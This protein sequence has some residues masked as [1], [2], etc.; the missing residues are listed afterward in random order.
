MKIGIVCPYSFDAPGGVQY[1]VRDLATE[2]IKRGHDVDVLAPVEKA[3]VPDFITAVSGS[4]SIP[5]NG[6]VAQLSLSPKAILETR[7]WLEHGNFD[8][9]HIHEP[10]APSI[11]LIALA[12]AKSPIVATFHTSMVKSR[13]LGLA[14]PI[15]RPLL[16]RIAGRIAVSNEARRTLIEHQGGDAVIIPNGVY[17]EPLATA[18]DTPE[19]KGTDDAPVI[20]WLGRLDEPRKGLHVLADAIGPVVEQH[21]TARFLIGGRGDDAPV[22]KLEEKFPDNVEFVGDVNP[23]QRNS[24]YHGAT[25]YIAPQ[26]GGESFGIVLVEAMSAGTCVIA[27]D[28]EAFRLVLNGGQL[29]YLFTS[30]DSDDLARV[31]NHALDNPEERKKLAATGHEASKLYDW[32][33]VTDKILAVY[34]TVIGTA[35]V[36]VSNTDTLLDSVRQVLSRNSDAHSGK[37]K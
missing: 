30:G 23:Q 4:Y 25:A 13:A 22:R 20:F 11:S 3:E 19:W 17:R 16:D 14:V 28:I 1:H 34:A 9:V 8:V 37:G 33:V 21:P 6:S 32:G 24:L 26:T 29:G 15:L 7:A 10:L 35:S 18:E 31:I 12:N 27:S 5:Y 2:L 36:P